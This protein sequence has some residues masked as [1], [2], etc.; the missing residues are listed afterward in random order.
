MKVKELTKEHIS[1]THG[2]KLQCGEGQGRG[3]VAWREVEKGLGAMEMR[4]ICNSVNNE[5]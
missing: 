4:D 2:Y 1:V 3:C 5:K